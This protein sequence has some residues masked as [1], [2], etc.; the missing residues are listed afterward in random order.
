[1]LTVYNDYIIHVMSIIEIIYR[2]KKIILAFK[3]I[4]IKLK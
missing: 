1:M 4:T 3:I 2:Q